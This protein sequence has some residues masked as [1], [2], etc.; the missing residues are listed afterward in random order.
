MINLI[1]IEITIERVIERRRDANAVSRVSR[2]TSLFPY[3]SHF[4]DAPRKRPAQLHLAMP[5]LHANIF[6]I[7]KEE[8][9]AQ[10]DRSN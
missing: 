5:E 4:G 9:R 3:H 7:G 2:R 8:E 10:R 1:R 6:D